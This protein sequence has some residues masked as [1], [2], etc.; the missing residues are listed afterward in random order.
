RYQADALALY[1]QL[2]GPAARRLSGITELCIVPDGAL[3]E[4]PFP[5]L[6]TRAEKYLVQ[7]YAVFYSPSLAV[8]REMVRL[9]GNDATADQPAQLLAVGNPK[10]SN[11][12]AE[13][14]K[15]AHRD[16]SLVPL[17]EAEREVEALRQ[18]YGP[19]RSAI[20]T[21]ANAREENVKQELPNYR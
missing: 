2:I 14:I 19:E 4:L 8:L 20:F 11:Q 7:D 6:L 3:W 12:M 10:V 18:L 1:R 17:P 15:V 21:E 5:A 13:I 16:E 9:R